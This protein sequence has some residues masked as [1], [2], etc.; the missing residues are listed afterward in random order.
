MKLNHKERDKKFY[1]IEL[2]GVEVDKKG[3]IWPRAAKFW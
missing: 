1:A 3:W 2:F